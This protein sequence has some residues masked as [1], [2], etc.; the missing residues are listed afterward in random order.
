MLSLDKIG[1]TFK[2]IF[3]GYDFIQSEVGKTLVSQDKFP[4]I[5]RTTYMNS[6]YSNV[7]KFLDYCKYEADGYL[8][9]D[10][11]NKYH[12]GLYSL[13]SVFDDNNP[14]K[15]NPYVLFNPKIIEQ[16][17]KNIELE[18]I[19]FWVCPS[20]NELGEVEAIGFR[21]VDTNTVKN[22][23]KWIFTCGNNI[24]YGKNTVDKEKPV[25]VVEGYRDYIALRELGYNVIGLG[26]V[27][28]SERQ[29]RYIDT[30]NPIILLDNDKF[31][32]KKSL[33][34]GDFYKIALLTGTNQKDAYDAFIRGDKIEIC[35]IQ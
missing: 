8:P 30:L 31:G 17:K 12:C 1:L 21:V 6:I 28:I 13:N 27:Y 4:H 3:D 11:M 24:I 20:F 10:L 19:K 29:K 32:L 33:Q 22:C 34:Y 7:E 35:Q 16:L 9:K 23:F 18:D 25:Y 5:I 15:G 14:W 26:S 2:I